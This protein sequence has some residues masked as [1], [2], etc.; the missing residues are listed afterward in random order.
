MDLQQLQALNDAQKARY[1]AMGKLFEHP[2]Y[3]F[4]M[5]WAQ[6]S[7]NEATGRELNAPTWDLTLLN[8][9]ARLAFIDLVNLETQVENEFTA[10]AD[11]ALQTKVES[12]PEQ[13][14][15]DDV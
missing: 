8:R 7:V 10:L 11:E 1:M 5:E 4:L 9:G 3:K 6:S 2:S 13:S 12:Q 14:G 15:L